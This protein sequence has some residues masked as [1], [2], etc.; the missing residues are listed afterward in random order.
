M[1]KICHSAHRILHKMNRPYTGI[2]MVIV[3]GLLIY[4]PPVVT[5]ISPHNAFLVSENRKLADFPDFRSQKIEDFVIKFEQYFREQI[6]FRQTF[7]LVYHYIKLFV[8][9]TSPHSATIIGENGWL[10]FTTENSLDDVLGKA[11]ISEKNLKQWHCALESRKNWLKEQGIRYLFVVAPDKQSIY[12]EYL[13]AKIRQRAVPQKRLDQLLEHMQVN[14][15]VPIL[16]LR[17]PLM[18]AKQFHPVYY[19]TDTHWNWQGGWIAYNQIMAVVREWFPFV[20]V[21]PRSRILESPQDYTTGDLNRVISHLLHESE[22]ALFVANPCSVITDRPFNPFST[23]TI[24]QD[25]PLRV[26]VFHDSFFCVVTPFLSET[27][28]TTI[29][30]WKF[31]PERFS[32]DHQW[33]KQ[34]IREYKPDLVIEE[35]VERFLGATPK[36]TIEERFDFSSKEILRIDPGNGFTGVLPKNDVLLVPQPDRLDIHATGNDPQVSLPTFLPGRSPAIMKIDLISP[37]DTTLQAFYLNRSNS[38]YAEKRSYLHSVKKG[39]NVI[40]I[41]I[42]EPELAGNIRL[43]PGKLVGEYVIRSIQIRDT[44]P[45]S[46]IL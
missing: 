3:F 36:L 15:D 43:D 37:D 7:I 4:L 5:L 22:V 25:A 24:C 8:F 17:K 12:P 35:R 9:N 2:I 31:F 18:D 16:D 39:E 6:G 1:S 27:F 46:G 11:P 29:N 20:D 41:E 42:D 30:L 44:G 13:P 23:V 38:T 32:Y 33:L 14:S 10:F 40:Y 19:R 26:I 45:C 28:G 34:L 21:L